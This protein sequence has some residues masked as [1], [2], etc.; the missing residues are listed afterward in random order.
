MQISWNFKTICYNLK[1]RRLEAKLCVAF[2]LTQFWKKLWRFKV[3]ESM[4]FFEEKYTTYNIYNIKYIT[5]TKTKRNRKLKIPHSFRE[6]SLPPL[7]IE[8]SPINSKTVM[9]W[10]FQK[11]KRTFFVPFFFCSKTFF[12][13]RVL[14]QSIV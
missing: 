2:L 13:V 1:I 5:L 12:K 9:S 7:P 4:Q 11:K 10:S 3:K 8:E 6:P 14:S